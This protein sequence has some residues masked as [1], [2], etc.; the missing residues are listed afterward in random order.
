M[1]LSTFTLG[2]LLGFFLIPTYSHAS[3][4]LLDPSFEVSQLPNW[5]VSGSGSASRASGINFPEHTGLSSLLVLMEGGVSQAT[6]PI[7]PGENVR[8]S[9]YYF[10]PSDTDPANFYQLQNGAY[11]MLQIVFKDSGGQVLSTVQSDPLMPPTDSIWREGAVLGVA[12]AGTVSMEVGLRVN[13]TA[14]GEGNG[15]LFFDDAQVQAA[16]EPVSTALIAFAI[17]L[18]GTGFYRKLRSGRTA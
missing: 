10:N 9:A 1:K 7:S 13:P 11:G 5:T 12:P 16:P 3:I 17:M 18:T 14:L 4:E 8:F 6:S 2:A 15:W